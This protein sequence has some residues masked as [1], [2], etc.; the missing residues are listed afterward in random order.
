M[1]KVVQIINGNIKD[2]DIDFEGLDNF[3]NIA[4]ICKLSN[5]NNFFQN[6]TPGRF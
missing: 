3:W 5:D 4:F 1:G 6:I 2:D